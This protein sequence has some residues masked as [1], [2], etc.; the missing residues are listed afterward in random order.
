M[1]A[2][3]SG[4]VIPRLATQV[5]CISSLN[6]TNSCFSMILKMLY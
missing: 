1:F 3:L 4:R 6:G 2:R 5:R